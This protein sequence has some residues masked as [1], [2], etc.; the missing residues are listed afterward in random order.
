VDFANPESSRGSAYRMGALDTDHPC[1]LELPG[2][3]DE[4]N[5]EQACSRIRRA[6]LSDFGGAL[7]LVLLGLGADGHIASLFPG[8]PLLHDTSLTNTSDG[9]SLVAFIDDSPKPPLRRITLTMS[10]LSS[11]PLAIL[12]AL[13][14]SKRDAL[15]RVILGD[16]DL[17]ASRIS[18]LCILTDLDL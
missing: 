18:N 2:W 12:V 3:L 11:A 7:D 17:P 13:G 8:H 15:A 14:E 9:S 5:P 6:L 16:A 4:E 1:M 10:I